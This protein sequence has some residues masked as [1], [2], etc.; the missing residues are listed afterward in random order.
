MKEIWKNF[1]AH[2]KS[3]RFCLI[4]ITLGLSFVAALINAFK[5]AFPFTAFAGIINGLSLGSYILKSFGAG[6]KERRIN[7]IKGRDNHDQ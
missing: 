1:V 5:P 7:N 6:E 2:T 4:L 3:S